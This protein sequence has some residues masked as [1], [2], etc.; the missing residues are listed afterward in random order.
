M[1]TT[2]SQHSLLPSTS[3]RPPARVRQLNRPA[4]Q[5]TDG[6]AD[7][8]QGSFRVLRG[9]SALVISVAARRA[10]SLHLDDDTDGFCKQEVV[11]KTGRSR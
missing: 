5:P 4:V 11:F 9:P 1:M 3:I 6:A 10:P 7:L 8:V 2:E